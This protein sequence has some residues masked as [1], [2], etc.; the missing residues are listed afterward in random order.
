MKDMSISKALMWLFIS[1][2]LSILSG[3]L[4]VL[5]IVAFVLNL[6]ALY[7]AGRKDQ[8]YKTAF[9]LSIVGIVVSIV[10]AIAGET[11]LGSIISI[12]SIV[13]N[14]GIL[15]YVVITTNS[16]LEGSDAPDLAAKGNN[17][18]K[19][20]LICSIAAVVLTVLL[21]IVP[22]LAAVLAIVVGI[23]EIVAAILYMIY[24]YKSS[25]ALA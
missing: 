16:C 3:L 4:A 12:I 7:G 18:W 9:I 21:L 20:N 5:G 24:L 1:Q 15:Y 8:G 13:I 2:I 23:V 19:L 10:G 11:V 22:M 25:K 14:L 6:L 17:V